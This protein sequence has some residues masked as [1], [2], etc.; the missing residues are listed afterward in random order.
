MPVP[1]QQ[2]QLLTARE[3][4]VVWCHRASW[5]L[6]EGQF[7][8]N[9]AV[10]TAKWLLLVQGDAGRFAQCMGLIWSLNSLCN[11]FI[12]PIMG[13]LS[14]SFSRRP[15]IAATRVGLTVYFW[16]GLLARSVPQMVAVEVLAWGV[17]SAGGLA[18]QA[19]SLDDMFG[20]RPELNSVIQSQNAAFAGV[21]GC[22]GPLLGILCHERGWARLSYLLPSAS[23]VLQAL[24][25]LAAPE[26]LLPAKR[27]PFK[28]VGA[29]PLSNCALLLRNGSSLRRLTAAS[30]LYHACTST[31]GTQE[32]YRTQALG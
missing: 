1:A 18:V 24:L 22:L 5:F 11:L 2:P 8:V 19:A 25:F 30:M 7:G 17:L 9:K 29:N 14:D 26:T 32:A 28:L 23:L 12:N 10:R 31:W 21:S 13:A 15:I 20:E 4:R 27:R 16:G 3:R 6:W